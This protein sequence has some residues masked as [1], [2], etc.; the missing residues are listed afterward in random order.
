M[1]MELTVGSDLSDYASDDGVWIEKLNGEF[2][3]AEEMCV[4]TQPEP[5]PITSQL[6]K[7]WQAEVLAVYE[8]QMVRYESRRYSLEEA[9]ATNEWLMAQLPGVFNGKSEAYISNL[10]E[11]Y[12]KSETIIRLL[13]NHGIQ[14]V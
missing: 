4:P 13:G 14:R 10:N 3:S 5:K 7:E 1:G 2:R 9:N 11:A 6:H 8:K 12:R